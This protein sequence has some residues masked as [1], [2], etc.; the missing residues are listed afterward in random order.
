MAAKCLIGIQARSNNQRLPGKC[1]KKVSKTAN[2]LDMVLANCK[3]SSEYINKCSSPK[4]QSKIALLVPTDD[5]LAKK[6]RQKVFTIEG[7]EMDVLSRYLTAFEHYPDYDYICRVT[8]D[9]PLL[10]AHIIT[11]HIHQAVIRDADYITNAHPD[12]RTSPDGYDV[13][14]IS[15][16][17]FTYMAQS[18][19]T[20]ED[21]EHVTLYLKR[22]PPKWLKAVAMVGHLD[23]SDI[24]ISVDT[25][26]ELTAVRDQ[27][28]RVDEK[29]K[30]LFNETNYGLLRY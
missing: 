4:I 19:L 2:M 21:K 6:Y 20:A 23:L 26:D 29:I 28:Q 7:D 16:R 1:L 10:P 3:S 14:V 5:P 11:K 12:F 15:K 27:Y 24:K 25:A 22:E 9:C 17:A 30:K 18:E 13:E 8:S